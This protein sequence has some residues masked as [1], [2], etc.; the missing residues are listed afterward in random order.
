VTGKGARESAPPN[1]SRWIKP[2]F[3]VPSRISLELVGTNPSDYNLRAAALVRAIR[4]V[5][6]D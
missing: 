1:L 4:S 6:K 3:R 2:P 5:P